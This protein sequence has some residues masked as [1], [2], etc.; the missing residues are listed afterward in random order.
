MVGAKK[1][2][3]IEIAGG[4]GKIY[5]VETW[6]RN[7]IADGDT[8]SEYTIRPI[9]SAIQGGIDEYKTFETN[10]IAS[11]Y[12]LQEQIDNIEVSGGGRDYTNSDNNI[13]IV[14]STINLNSGISA[15]AYSATYDKNGNIYYSRLQGDEL[16][17]SYGH[18]TT[19]ITNSGVSYATQQGTKFA[20]WDNIFGNFATVS[21]ETVSSINLTADKVNFVVSKIPQNYKA[22]NFVVTAQLPNDLAD[23]TYYIV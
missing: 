1:P 14:D 21:R 17:F 13:K 8:M 19:I 5:V 16:S 20:T 9:C 10:I 3:P 23:D 11:A 2:E 12:S 22:V 6:N 18:S 15:F 7:T 4:N